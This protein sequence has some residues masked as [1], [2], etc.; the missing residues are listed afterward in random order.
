MPT[1]REKIIEELKELRKTGKLM[2]YDDICD[3]ILKDRKRIIEEYKITYF[4][5]CDKDC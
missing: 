3:F 1:P 2:S 5:D 4:C